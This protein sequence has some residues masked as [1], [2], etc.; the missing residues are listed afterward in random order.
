[1]RATTIICDGR[2]APA[3]CVDLPGGVTR[4]HVCVNPNLWANSTEEA[5]DHAQYVIDRVNEAVL[6]AL[7]NAH[8][9][10]LLRQEQEP[11][12]TEAH[13]NAAL[14]RGWGV[15]ER[16]DR[17]VI[18]RWDELREFDSDEEAIAHVRRLAEQG[19]ELCRRALRY[20]EAEN[21]Y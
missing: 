18:Q 13:Q 11:P 15:F 12:W 2:H 17:P 1:M 9:F 4:T 16:E 14:V 6:T 5:L 19:D 10:L 20:V 21:K 3:I 7:V 8:Q